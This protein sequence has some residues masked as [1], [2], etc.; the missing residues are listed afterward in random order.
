MLALSPALKFCFWKYSYVLHVFF[1]K[2][3][4]EMYLVCHPFIYFSCKSIKLL[5]ITAFFLS[6][7]WYHRQKPGWMC[8]CF[9]WLQWRCQQSHQCSPGRKSRHGRELIT[10]LRMGVWVG[11]LVIILKVAS[12][13]MVLK[14]PAFSL[15]RIRNI[16]RDPGRLQILYLLYT[17][18]LHKSH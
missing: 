15:N 10:F 13:Q 14:Q 1:F 17:H 2:V 6:V 3:F 7:D 8:D 4:F 12:R 18:P 16:H 9:A 11:R 5:M